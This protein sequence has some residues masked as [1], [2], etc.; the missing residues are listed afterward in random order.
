MLLAALS[1]EVKAN[2]PVPVKVLF[3]AVMLTWLYFILQ[4]VRWVWLVTIGIYVLGLAPYLISDSL[5]WQ[6][7]A[8]SLIGLILLLLPVTRRYFPSNASRVDA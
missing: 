1:I 4:G 6:G 5:T 3:A 2:G 7:L 8:L